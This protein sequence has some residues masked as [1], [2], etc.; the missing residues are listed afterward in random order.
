M[1]VQWWLFSSLFCLALSLSSV[2]PKTI[3][4]LVSLSLLFLFSSSSFSSPFL[5]RFCSF[6]PSALQKNFPPSSCLPLSVRLPF[7]LSLKFCPPVRSSLSQKNCPPTLWF[8]SLP[9]IYRQPGERFTIPCPS[10]GHG[11]VG[12]AGYG[13]VGVGMGHAGFLGKWGGEREGKNSG[14]I[15]QNSPSPLSLHL[16]G[17]RSCTVPFKTAPCSFFFEEKEKKIGSDPKLGYDN[18]A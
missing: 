5:P 17:R 1:E 13:C 10:A 2:S 11:G 6:L 16:Q 15:F 12:V 18:L 3:P 8:C 4:R 9:S 14:K 7:S